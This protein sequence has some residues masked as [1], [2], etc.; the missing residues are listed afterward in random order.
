MDV[1]FVS[2]LGGDGNVV[3][4]SNLPCLDFQ[5]VNYL[6]AHEYLF[7]IFHAD[8]QM[9]IQRIYGMRPFIKCVFHRLSIIVYILNYIKGKG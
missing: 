5:L 3:G 8:N 9:I 1:V 7:S 4:R 6:F 2:L